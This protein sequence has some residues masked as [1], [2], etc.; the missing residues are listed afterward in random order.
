MLVLGKVLD[1][2][3]D[4]PYDFPSF[5]F[6][7]IKLEEGRP[8]PSPSHLKR[9]IIIKNKKLKPEQEE[10]E[11][12]EFFMFHLDTGSLLMDTVPST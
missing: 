3:S 11:S 1:F 10:G 5:N 9:R 6:F 2:L 7:S 8:L 4:S 12:K